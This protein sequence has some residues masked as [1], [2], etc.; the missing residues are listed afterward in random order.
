MDDFQRA[1]AASKERLRERMKLVPV[2]EAKVELTVAQKK[3]VIN[4]MLGSV[5]KGLF[6]DC[7]EFWAGMQQ[8]EIDQQYPAYREAV[9]S[10][11]DGLKQHLL[12]AVGS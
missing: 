11:V 4:Y 12:R 5:G 7:Q 6:E 3:L 8:E 9:E 1:I 10:F 2:E